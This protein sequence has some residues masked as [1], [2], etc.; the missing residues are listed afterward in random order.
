MQ[1][2]KFPFKV[3]QTKDKEYHKYMNIL[4]WISMVGEEGERGGWGETPRSLECPS[5]ESR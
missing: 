5:L 2:N 4:Y 1:D 3:A